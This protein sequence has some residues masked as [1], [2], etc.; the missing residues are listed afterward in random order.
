MSNESVYVSA[1]TGETYWVMGDLFTYLVTG[2]ESGGSYFTGQRT[3]KRRT[4]SPCS[5]SGRRTVI[6]FGG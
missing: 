5:S 4:S 1:N 2:A 6:C 3:A